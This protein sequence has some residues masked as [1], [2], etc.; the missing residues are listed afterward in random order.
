M[1]KYKT[2]LK[3][4]FP[5]NTSKHLIFR[6]AKIEV[7]DIVVDPMCGGGSIPIE[8]SLTYKTAM[9]IGG[10]SHIKAVERS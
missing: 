4:F 5:L 9:H 7:G 1:L 8:G 6:V 2:K 10:D 3:G